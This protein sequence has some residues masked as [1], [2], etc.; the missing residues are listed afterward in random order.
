MVLPVQIALAVGVATNV[1]LPPFMTTR[2]VFVAVMIAGMPF[3]GT[4]FAPALALLSAGAKE[5]ELNQGLA[6]ALSN[7]AWAGGQAVAAPVKRRAGTGDIGRRPLCPARGG[8]PHHAGRRPAAGAPADRAHHA[9]AIQGAAD[10]DPVAGRMSRN[11][12]GRPRCSAPR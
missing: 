1:L 3:L 7:L 8:P 6:F 4:L 12:S 9:R 5:L 2:L 11:L 10:Q